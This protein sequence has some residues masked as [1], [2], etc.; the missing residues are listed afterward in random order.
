MISRILNK[1]AGVTLIEL[2]ISLVIISILL[3]LATYIFVN[4]LSTSVTQE[5]TTAAQ[6][7]VQAVLQ[8]I[9]WDILMT[10]Y[11]V[12]ADQIAIESQN[13][14]GQNNSDILTLKSLWFGYETGGH[15]SY[16]LD[17]VTNQSIIPVRNWQDPELDIQ[18]GDKIVF[19]TSTKQKL[20]DQFFEVIARDTFTHTGGIPGYRL[21]LDNSV[22]TSMNFLF[23]TSGTGE[24]REVV[25]QLQ[26]NVLMRDSLPMMDNVM[27]FQ[28]AYW[29]DENDN[30]IQEDSEWHNDLDVVLAD[31]NLKDDIRLIRLNI[32]MSTQAEKEYDVQQTI[33][34][35]DN[36]ITPNPNMRHTPWT[37]VANPRNIR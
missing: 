5:R 27:D 24:L 29:V 33:T 11:S 7:D 18:V 25:Y 20:N 30:Q 21:T 1:K 37:Q 34:L 12:S 9:K 35:E 17:P 15:W 26:N 23:N 2:L 10:G 22:S 3:S 8:Q 32:L 31:P 28:V 19:L 4:F 36:T 6:S 16:V 14:A 13:N